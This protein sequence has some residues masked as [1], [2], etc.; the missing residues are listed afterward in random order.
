MNAP[1]SRIT[2]LSVCLAL[3]MLAVV[4]VD[5]ATTNGG[6]RQTQEADMDVDLAMRALR[7]APG[8]CLIEF[9]GV[10]GYLSSCIRAHAARP[11]LLPRDCIIHA[12]DGDHMRRLYA[13]TCMAENG[14]SE[15]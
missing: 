6:N 13:H 10:S 7:S 3:A 2:A 1:F 5:A 12:Q 8:F 15:R 4:A 14:W 9:G 11:N